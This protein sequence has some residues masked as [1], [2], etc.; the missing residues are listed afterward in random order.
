MKKLAYLLL[1]LISLNTSALTLDPYVATYKSLVR[2]MGDG[3]SQV[4]IGTDGDSLVIADLVLAN[5]V[6]KAGMN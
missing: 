4:R 1:G 6:I 2:T 5:S 3:G